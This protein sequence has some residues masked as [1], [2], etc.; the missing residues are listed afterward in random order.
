[1]VA[2][3]LWCA[4]VTILFWFTLQRKN[5]RK[6]DS[7]AQTAINTAN[8]HAN[9]AVAKGLDATDKIQQH[10]QTLIQKAVIRI[11]WYAVF[12]IH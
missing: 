3:I 1:M 4:A 2:S 9:N 8:A 12:S 5:K 11:A 7:T 6:M 10:S